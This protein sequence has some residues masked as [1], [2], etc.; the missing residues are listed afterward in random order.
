MV[1]Q[2]EKKILDGVDP[3]EMYEWDRYLSQEIGSRMSGTEGDR[4]AIK[5]VTDH[6]STHGLKTEHDHFNTLS[7]E[8][9][10]VTFKVGPPLNALLDSRAAYYSHPTPEG[11]VEG[12][13]VFVGRGTEEEFSATDVQGKIVMA[14]ASSADPLFWLGSYSNRAKRYG[15][16]A[17]VVCN[18]STVAFTPSHR[19]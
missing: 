2:Q 9:H 1:S 15:A 12:E 14:Q 8:Y 19:P 3:W 16:L 18:G 6:F 11:G 5:W 10:G 7:W 13:L 4:K 17:F